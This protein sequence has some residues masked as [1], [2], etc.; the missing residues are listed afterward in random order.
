MSIL[1]SLGYMDGRD[2]KYFK[3]YI[4][5]VFIYLFKINKLKKKK[6]KMHK[7][8]VNDEPNIEI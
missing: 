3:I 5:L 6:I 8:C 2:T 1:E 7:I 4:I